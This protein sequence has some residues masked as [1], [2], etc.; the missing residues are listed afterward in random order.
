MS[1]HIDRE[2]IFK[3]KNQNISGT[4]FQEISSLTKLKLYNGKYTKL[5]ICDHEFLNLHNDKKFLM[6]S[7]PIA[8]VP[9]ITWLMCKVNFDEFIH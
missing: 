7:E 6:D 3:T 1:L 2:A 8:K 5:T 9:N 4:Q